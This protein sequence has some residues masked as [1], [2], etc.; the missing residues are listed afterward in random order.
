MN[1]PQTGKA[2]DIILNVGSLDVLNGGALASI[3]RGNGPGGN[4]SINA[5]S[6]LVFGAKDRGPGLTPEFIP[7]NI[8][9]TQEN[10]K[11]SAPGGS[12]TIHAG[13]LEVSAGGEIGT[14]TFGQGAGGKLE[15]DVTG[16]MVVSGTGGSGPSR[17]S[18]GSTGGGLGGDLSI[19]AANLTIAAGIPS[20]APV[21]EGRAAT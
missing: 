21:P 16:G 10:P 18:A 5:G 17:V 15:L 2:G 12:V 19:A 14:D 4:I 8:N 9:A 20:T 7:T 1:K 11:A 13:S 6:V 3:A